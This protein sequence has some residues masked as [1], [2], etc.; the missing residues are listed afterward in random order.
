MSVGFGISPNGRWSSVDHDNCGRFANDALQQYLL[1]YFTVD[2]IP[3]DPYDGGEFRGAQLD[4]LVRQLESAVAEVGTQPSEWPFHDEQQQ[5]KYY[6]ECRIYEIEPLPP[7]D[8]ALR[9]LR[10]AITL[11]TKARQKNASLVFCGD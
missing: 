1:D 3:V 2:D 7:R 9:T 6:E 5:A 11:A 4:T 8:Q 10:Q